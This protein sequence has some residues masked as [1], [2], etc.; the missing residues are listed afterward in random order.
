MKSGAAILATVLIAT[1]AALPL[2]RS[3]SAAEATGDL[4]T[5]FQTKSKDPVQVD[6]KS[7]EISEEGQ[8]RISVFSGDVVIR[9]GATTMKAT[10]VK[11]FSDLHPKP[12]K[13][14]KTDPFTRIEASGPVYVTS[15]L[16]TVTGGFAVVDMKEQTITLTGDV[17]MTQGQDIMSGERLV[18]DLRTGKAKVD[19]APGKPI[20]I[21]ISP[22]AT[23][24][25]APSQ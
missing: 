13:N 23:Q 24:E 3:A 9:R 17:V 25:P 4:F 7:L 2:A 11:L 1:L 5:G 22:R 21:L 10:V 6:A 12:K 19:Q 15:G 20:H 8:Q 16:Q 14:G 18:V